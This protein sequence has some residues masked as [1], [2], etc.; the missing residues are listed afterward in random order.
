MNSI[1]YAMG[2]TSAPIFFKAN[3][4]LKSLTGSDS[5]KIAA[6]YQMGCL[7]AKVYESKVP[8]SPNNR[9]STI[10]D[11]LLSSLR[12]KERKY[13]IKLDH[14]G[15]ANALAIPG[16][17]IYCTEKLFDLCGED[18]DAIAFVLAHEIAHGIHGDANKRFLTKAVIS[19]LLRMKTPG[20]N[21]AAQSLL[22]RL[23]QQGYSREQEFR[24]DRFAVALTKAAGFDPTGGCRL[25]SMLAE[26]GKEEETGMSAYFSSHPAHAERIEQINRR[27]REI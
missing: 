7:L 16:G 12:N 4:I 18:I 27:I 6:E 2:R 26:A 24:A 20:S 25:F 23:V 17:F 5:E 14:S 21:P 19:G 9:L 15:E 3:W 8:T 22:A 1:A 11:K 10:A 13:S